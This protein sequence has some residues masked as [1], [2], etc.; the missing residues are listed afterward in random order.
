MIRKLGN[1][2][3][4]LALVLVLAVFGLARY[5]SN[6]KGENTFKT[7]IIPSIDSARMNG[8]I[9]F[10]NSM[11]P[12]QRR[13]KV[14]IESLPFIFSRK[15]KEWYIS[16]GNV[17]GLAQQRSAQYMMNQLEHITP[18]RLASDNPADWK[19][20][21]VNDSLGTRVV[22]LYDKDTAL[23][24][25]VGRFSY[26]PDRKQAISYIRIAG[27]KEVYAINGMLSM[28]I[29]EDFDSW[30]D[31]KMMPGESYDEWNKLTFS[32]PADS[33]F[34]M[35]KDSGSDWTINNGKKPDSLAALHILKD[36]S[37]QNYGSFVNNFDSSGKQPICMLTIEGKGFS[38]VTIKAWAADSA[39]VYAIN[40]SINPTSFFSGRRGGMFSK[41]FPAKSAF[42]RK[43]FKPLPAP[44]RSM[45]VKGRM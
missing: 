30:R 1:K 40:S 3:L 32:Y 2:S 8:M 25:I 42:F 44:I 10:P 14:A 45:P 17:S 24:V 38:P 31:K 33:G 26:V 23:D 22:F 36:L 12:G 28:N 5:I 43:D 9:I 13:G 37:E 15:G 39:N 4:L 29:N 7:A 6:K 20:Y 16:K 27:Q 21:N 41:I 18:D 35:K 34:I 19:E 11:M